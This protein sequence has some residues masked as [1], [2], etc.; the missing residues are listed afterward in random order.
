MATSM[1]DIVD[2]FERLLERR[3]NRAWAVAYCA[4]SDAVLLR[5]TTGRGRQ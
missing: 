2:D 5:I 3:R 1:S 4:C